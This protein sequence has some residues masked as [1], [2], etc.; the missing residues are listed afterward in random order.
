MALVTQFDTP[1]S[2]RDLP[3]GHAFYAN[4]HTFLATRLNTTAATGTGTGE[5]YDASEVNVDILAEHR[6]VWMAFPRE[7]LVAN[8]DNRTAAFIAADAAVAT[9]NP[10][11]EYCEWHV[12]RN[13]AGNV[14]WKASSP[15]SASSTSQS[16]ARSP[17]VAG[18]ASPVVPR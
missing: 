4:W 5:F 12:T 10:Q 17:S 6:L 8:R 18:A 16:V 11:N 1:A 13:G 14:T 3:V 7:V 9:R 2:V 15:A